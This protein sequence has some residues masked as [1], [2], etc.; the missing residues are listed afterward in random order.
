[1]PVGSPAAS[2]SIR[3][4]G[5]S[6]VCLSMPARARAAPFTQA[7]WPS[8][9][10]RYTG[11]SATT[12]SS[13]VAGRQPAGEDRH[14]PA[15]AGDPGPIRVRG[16][17][18]LDRGDALGRRGVPGQVALQQLPPADTGCTCASWKP[19][20]SRPPARSTCCAPGPRRRLGGGPVAHGHDPPVAHR[21]RRGRDRTPWPVNTL[22]PL[23]TVTLIEP[24]PFSGDLGR[25]LLL[26]QQ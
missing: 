6:G 8:A 2:R 7:P 17:V 3:P 13:K 11:R 9:L 12:A 23:N 24:R 26:D 4:S 1:M 25:L 16:R 22:P 21:H 20:V 14:G 19:G 5:G 10:G 18:P 15:A